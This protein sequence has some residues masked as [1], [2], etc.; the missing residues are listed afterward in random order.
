MQ[1]KTPTTWIE[2]SPGVSGGDAC[3]RRTRIPVWLLVSLKSQGMSE[4]KLL[5]GYPGLTQEDLEAAWVYYKD[6]S[7]EIDEAI[8]EQENEE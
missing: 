3:I 2:K 8:R 5:E 7:E 1:T 6:H 4:V